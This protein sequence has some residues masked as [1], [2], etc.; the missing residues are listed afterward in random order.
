[1]DVLVELINDIYEVSIGD[2]ES[3]EEFTVLA[4]FLSKKSALEWALTI[5]EEIEDEEKMFTI[6][7]YTQ[8]LEMLA[9]SKDE[10]DGILELIHGRS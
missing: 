5:F 10:V 8:E 1:M 7:D 3:S 2:F 4:N 6:L 9:F